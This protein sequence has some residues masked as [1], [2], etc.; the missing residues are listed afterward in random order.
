MINY[1]SVID[2]LTSLINSDDLVKRS[3][4]V[5]KKRVCFCYIDEMTDKILFNDSVLVPLLK[6]E[7][8]KYPYLNQ[9]TNNLSYPE[10]IKVFDTPSKVADVITGGDIA[11]VIDDAEGIFVLSLRKYNLRAIAEPPTQSVL[12]GPREGFIED[13]KTNMSLLRRSIRSSSLRIKSLKVGK[14]KQNDVAVAYVDGIAE[15]KI[16]NQ[17]IA[18]IKSINI[19][20]VMDSSYICEFLEVRKHSIFTQIGQIEKPDIVSGKLLEGRVAVFLDGSPIV[21]T[22]PYL[23]IESFQDSYDYYTKDYRATLLRIFRLLALFAT[24]ILPGAYVAFQDFHYHLLPIKFVITL[25]NAVN[26]IPFSPAIEMIIVVTLFEI[27]HQ[28]SIRMPRYLG[29]A[30]SVVGAIVLG[31]TAVRAGILSSPT[32]LII[33][34]SAIGMHC[35]PDS[36]DTFSILRLLLIIIGSIFGLFGII[37]FSVMLICYL[38]NIDN[39]GAPFLG[40]YAPMMPRDLQDGIIKHSLSDMKDRPYSIPTKNRRRQI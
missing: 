21:L 32:V 11:M 30:L 13:I 17:I 31:E 37:I 18:K 23:F 28:A 14:Y 25:L 3:F 39:Y 34:I 12:K 2:E 5:D 29:I 33:A 1:D 27:L 15:E 26:G 20:G 16:V 40:P 38:S 4:C 24:V 35:L 8:L 7:E 19:D 10:T 36:I 9:L 22:L 6:F